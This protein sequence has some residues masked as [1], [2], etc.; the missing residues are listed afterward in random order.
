MKKTLTVLLAIS[1]VVGM[2]SFVPIA[3][4][5]LDFWHIQNAESE[6]ELYEDA[7]ELFEEENPDVNVD[8]T[9]IEN[10]PYKDKLKVAMGADNPPDIWTSWG[11]GVLKEYVDG[12]KVADL[13]E[14]MNETG[15]IDNYPGATLNPV[16]FDGKIYGVPTET[17]AGAVVWYNETIF[18]E[19]DLE[20][21]ETW[22]ELE[23]VANTLKEN[24]ITPFSL[25]NK[26]S[27]PGTE[28]YEYLV[29]R[30]AGY[31]KIVKT[32]NN[33]SGH[34]MTDEPF[35]EAGRLI[36]DFISKDFF[37]KGYSSLSYDQGGSRRLLYA[38]QAAMEVMGSWEYAE[39]KSENPEWTEENMFLFTFP[40][41]EGGEGDPSSII[42]SP[43][44]NYLHVSKDV[45]NKEAAFDVLR[46]FADEGIIEQKVEIGHVPPVKG[47][48][49]LFED[50][51]I[52]ETYNLFSGAENIILYWD[53]LLAPTLTETHK[54]LCTQLLNLSITPEQYG[55]RMEEA[56]E[57]Y[58]EE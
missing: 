34:S 51:V 14:L 35:V 30:L 1:L 58:Y 24:G 42:G 16:T 8:I 37:N 9:V 10:D 44:Q 50:R 56:I 3:Q 25:A 4:E 15:H 32:L 18:E 45:E 27:W 19:Y 11:G 52:K 28:W 26:S 39:A 48:E 12:G 5:E 41:V 29:L 2:F 40:M 33:E 13:T 31:E 20:V 22:S 54:D 23:E 55:K 38:N 43:G 46:K 6:R 49:H 7:V 57:E 36:Q 21:P 53:Q 17:L 47:V